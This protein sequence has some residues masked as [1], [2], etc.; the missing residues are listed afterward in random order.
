MQ[1]RGIS[2]VQLSQRSGIAVSRLNAYV[3][4]NYSTLKPAH[5]AAISAA[6]DGTPAD[7]AALV[8]AYLFDLL[9]DGCRGL[10][11]IR[12][13]GARQ[14]GK[15]EV[16][17]EGVAA[18]IRRSPAETLPAVRGQPEGAAADGRM[19]HDHEGNE[20]VRQASIAAV[21]NV[22]PVSAK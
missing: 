17:S 12:V 14:A 13:P 7:N 6:L 1:D 19:D 8:E 4:G 3:H 15:W 20:E 16:P 5:L 9:P 2:Q 21:V 11:D 10:V 22:D 18:G